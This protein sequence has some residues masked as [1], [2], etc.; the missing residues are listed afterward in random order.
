[1]EDEQEMGRTGN[2]H[3]QGGRGSAGWPH[4]PPR[5]QSLLP[6]REGHIY[7]SYAEEGLGYGDGGMASGAGKGEERDMNGQL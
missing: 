2:G 6:S 7:M 4:L 1:M 3:S 5:V